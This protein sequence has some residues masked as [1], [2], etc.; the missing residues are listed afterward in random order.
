MCHLDRLYAGDF[1]IEFQSWFPLGAEFKYSQALTC[2]HAVVTMMYDE[3]SHVLL[4]KACG[5]LWIIK[6]ALH[7][8]KLREIWVTRSTEIDVFYMLLK[9]NLCAETLG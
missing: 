1:G 7:G 3:H 8:L 6:N 4:R 9:L 5:V 2:I